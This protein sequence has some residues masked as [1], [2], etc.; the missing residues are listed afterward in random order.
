MSPSRWRRLAWMG[1]SCL[2]IAVSSTTWTSLADEPRPDVVVAD[3][4]GDDYHGWTT[5]GD[6][7][8]KGPARGT[9]PGQMSVDGFEGRGLVNSFL[10]GD[11]SRGTLTSPSITIDRPYLNFLIGGGGYAGETCVD[12]LI[13]GKIVRSATGP[14]VKPGGSERLDWTSWNVSEFAGK[15]AVIRVVDQKG[16]S[17]GHINVDQFVQSDRK[18]GSEPAVKSLVIDSPY[19]DLPVNNKAPVRRVRIMK[20]AAIVRE[21]DIKLAEEGAADF[22]VFCDLKPFQGDH[23]RVESTLPTGSGGLAEV[24]QSKEVPGAKEMYHEAI[25]P[26]FHFTSRRGWLNDPNGLVYHDGEY[27]LFYQHNP[28]GWD[29]GN[30]HWGH[31]VSPDL[32]HWNELGEALTPRTYG[33]W[34]FSGSAVVDRSNT[35]GFG[36]NNKAAMVLAYTSTGRGECIAYSNDR[37]RTWTEYEGNP[38]VKHAGRDPR[39]RW[40]EP[41][42]RWV[43][44][45]Y[46]ETGGTQAIA[47]HTSTDLKTWTPTSRIKGFYECPEFFPLNVNDDPAR[48]FWVLLAADGEYLIGQFDGQAFTPLLATKKRIWYGNFY[49]SQTFTNVPDGRRIQIGWG[50][51]VTFPRMPFNQQMTIPVALRLEETPDGIRML[52]APVAEL[53]TLR[54][55]CHSWN[56]LKSAPESNPLG[57]FKSDLY[58][59]RASADVPDDGKVSLNVRGVPMEYDASRETLSCAGHSAPLRRVN[60]AIQ[61]HIFVDRG[62][63]EIFGNQGRVALSCAIHPDE[64]NHA[65]TLSTSR[66]AARFSSLI[67]NELHSAWPDLKTETK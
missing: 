47:F 54:G 45:V 28:Y 12:L 16:G 32:V 10:G 61:L 46:D 41:S 43:M 57:E 53:T 50:R 29:W 19:L 24:V 22:R 30:M 1:G 40:F 56:D 67:V 58:E 55:P 15:S 3:F 17:W 62:S 49:A 52:A 21:F 23:L 18:R 2:A 63:I 51:D 4:E 20:D 14:N 25:R 11:D 8:G 59:I 36:L 33:D 48:P 9:L 34:C 37:G 26:Q 38:V 5:T 64:S 31:A 6:A 60:G 7:F 44:A 35:S 42:Q 65:L 39:L 13:D 27:H 66:G